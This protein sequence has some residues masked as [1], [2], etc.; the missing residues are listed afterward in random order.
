MASF[1]LTNA[2]VLINSVDHSDHVR[3]VKINYTAETPENTA[4]G[5]DHEDAAAGPQGLVGRDRVQ[6]GLRGG[7]RRREDVRA[8]RR[9]GLRGRVPKPVNGA[10]STSNPAYTG[11]ALLADY[12]P[13]GQKVG[14]TAVAPV[15]LVGTGALTRQTA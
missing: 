1:V 11:N 3:Q 7:E 15:K 6:P 12:A 8:G 9:R 2:Y 13:L 14:D 10:R 5:S 4:M